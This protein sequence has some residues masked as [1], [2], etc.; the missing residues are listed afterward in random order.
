MPREPSLLGVPAAERYRL[1]QRIACSGRT[2]VWR[3]LDRTSDRVV[4]VKRFLDGETYPLERRTRFLGQ[5]A[6]LSRAGRHPHLLEVLE[7]GEDERGLYV[8]TEF[9]EG[10]APLS[11]RLGS[12]LPCE[13]VRRVGLAL[14][15]A[16]AHLHAHG[17][18]HSMLTADK[19]LEAP[20]GAIRLAGVGVACLEDLGQELDADR[21]ELVRR[22]H[23]L[24]PEQA[25]LL[26]R[27]VGPPADLYALGALL[28]Q[29]LSGRPPFDGEDPG[30][31]LH[32]HLARRPPPLPEDVPDDLRE[33]VAEL[34]A[35]APEARPQRALA[36]AHALAASDDPAPSAGPV[37][38]RVAPL[39]GREQH[40]AALASLLGNA[41]SGRGGVVLLSGDAGS[42]KSRLMEALGRFAREASG[43]AVVGK[44]VEGARLRPLAP[45]ADAVAEYRLQLRG[46]PRE[47]RRAR[48]DCL[49]QR[50]PHV[51]SPAPAAE[52]RGGH[53]GAHGSRQ[54][55]FLPAGLRDRDEH[56]R[57]C[58]DFL[59]ALAELEPVLV[60]GIDD[61]Q[62][63]DEGTWELFV[64]L[65]G[66]ATRTS[67]L[68]VGAYRPRE[69]DELGREALERLRRQDAFEARLDPLSAEE[70][71][72]L[73]RA[74]LGVSEEDEDGVAA[75]VVARVGGN[76]LHL[77][78]VLQSLV[79]L[80]S[81]RTDGGRW[82]LDAERLFDAA[83]RAGV[84]DV[85]RSRAA[86]LGEEAYAAL[87]RAGT[88]GRPFSLDLF[89]E[90]SG[91][92]PSQ[93][94][95]ALEQGRAAGLLA[96]DAQRLTWS[97]T[98]D[99]VREALVEGLD[100]ETLRAAHAAVAAAIR[101][102]DP[103]EVAAELAEHLARAGRAAEGLEYDLKAGEQALAAF[104]LH[105][106]ARH[107]ERALEHLDAATDPHRFAHTVALYASARRYMGDY[108][109]VRELIERAL[110]I[111]KGL[112]D[113]DLELEL[114]GRRA[115]VAELAGGADARSLIE[116]FL[117]ASQ[118][119]DEKRIRVIGLAMLGYHHF[120]RGEP[121]RAVAALREALEQ[122]EIL[123]EAEVPNLGVV[124]GYALARLGHYEEGLRRM[125]EAAGRADRL[126]G[127]ARA[128]TQA[129][130]GA[131]HLEWEDW[132][133]GLP[134]VEEARQAL[135]GTG[136]V[137]YLVLARATSAL[138][139]ILSG[140][141]GDALCDLEAAIAFA[142]QR[143]VQ[144][145]LDAYRCMGGEAEL[146]LGRT[147]DGLRHVETALRGAR[148]RQ[149]RWVESRARR[150]LA[151][152]LCEDP[153]RRDEAE[154]HARA[155]LSL[156]ERVGLVPEQG[157][158]AR[159]LGK[160]LAARGERHA[161][162]EHWQRAE[163]IFRE[164]HL[165]A[166]LATLDALRG[167]GSGSFP[168]RASLRPTP[169]PSHDLLPRR[170]LQTIVRVSRSVGATLDADQL[171]AR[172][173]SAVVEVFGAE[174]GAVFLVAGEQLTLG[175]RHGSDGDGW[176]EALRVA[177]RV[178][179]SGRPA[180]PDAN[181]GRSSLCVPVGSPAQAI[182]Y[183][184]NRL[185]SDM[186]SPN[187]VLVLEAV[188]AHLAV[189]MENAHAYREI[190]R[191]KER[192]EEENIYLREELATH[193]FPEILGESVALR[194]A[195]R[196]VEQVAPLDTT[197]LLR[198]ETGVGKELFAR[199]IHQR[200]RRSSGPLV[201]VNCSALAPQ[202]AASELFGHEQGAFTGAV[203]RRIG[204]FELAAGGT[205]FLDEVG[206]LPTE[207]QLALLRVLQEREFERVGGSRTLRADVRVV[208]ATNRDLERAVE[209]GA[210]RR[211][212]FYRLNGFTIEVPPLRE[213]T[214]DVTL[215]AQAFA[216][217]H[218]RRLGK[219]VR[220]I[221]AEALRALEGYSW[222]GNVRELEHVIERAVILSDGPVLSIEEGLPQQRREETETEGLATLAENERRH[223]LRVLERTG[224][225]IKGKGGA[226]Q[227]LGLPPSTLTSKLKKHGLHRPREPR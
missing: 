173:L 200:S 104:Q 190:R 133:R 92:R 114:L 140:E 51:L 89:V 26:R 130:L 150:V 46:L 168:K 225:R 148:E 213:R 17:V 158:A 154:A 169:P 88:V 28:H 5:L 221:S 119:G 189:G 1:Q 115:M 18:V 187:D 209:E 7:A 99:K 32:G 35:K 172:V 59:Q 218:A 110:P 23:T 161:A 171:M 11:R 163:E 40:L 79:D 24:A 210:F 166:D 185:V 226:A 113:E 129:A 34:L 45:F 69:V 191:L 106:A 3:A 12:P 222:P 52:R 121:R 188:A 126:G 137:F 8:V 91:L 42:G 100:P 183:L 38:Q 13:E 202:L 201:R 6:A 107:F 146:R 165:W 29:L 192:L 33:L 220:E 212:L 155:S 48:E 108:P 78:E 43:R 74:H 31:V 65:A 195:L 182:L 55:P 184:E 67:M 138:G 36:V 2:E 75:R 82:R 199:A 62:W 58:Q 122:P 44:C 47:E 77:R 97:W 117:S 211:D 131:F 120:D 170:G 87:A 15:A 197:V 124:L 64:R 66:A 102:E 214:G 72:R 205:L 224:W 49:R 149:N 134:Y 193:D 216:L 81:L 123:D 128:W 178:W 95:L 112:G 177:E 208:A 19:V 132:Q 227:L 105:D 103:D 142:E 147:A 21:P 63:A 156:S 223:L 16:L 144:A 179:R 41:A 198:G 10:A 180:A 71:Q 93:A 9:V 61:L 94:L 219:E 206:D 162:A 84:T 127:A 153:L 164:S 159:A 96:A 68:L 90:V 37:L 111:A 25:G 181:T 39:V 143:G 174:R 175:A 152:Y 101:S 116:E 151:E 53:G 196:R 54:S 76:P 186:F 160:V 73:V 50:C 14:A 217:R 118:R 204:R 167:G 57:G 60:L 145:Y 20:S 194:R 98:H 125:E 207:T 109:H 135:E 70:A 176:G 27:P 56:F 215:L 80:G 141:I 22:F 85:I 157:R 83:L 139:R 30:A 136:D 86:R 4:A 203:S